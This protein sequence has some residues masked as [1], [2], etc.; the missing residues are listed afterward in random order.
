MKLHSATSIVQ[1]DQQLLN[2][3]TNTC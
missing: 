3:I 2:A 1:A